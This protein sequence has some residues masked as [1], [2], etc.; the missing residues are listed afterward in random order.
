MNVTAKDKATSK[1]QKVTITA[2]TN[3]NESEIERMVRQARDHE[4]E[5]RQRKEL[6]DARNTADNMVYQT[7]KALRELGDKVPASERSD[8][9]SKVS[10]LKQ[11]MQGENLAEIKR[12][13]EELQNAFYA[14]SQQMYAQGQ[15][16]ATSQGFGGTPPQSNGHGPED[17]GEVVE[18]E[19]RE[20]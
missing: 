19:F 4:A 11:T 12:Q 14:L 3:L 6:I 13:T 20:A 16:G 9:E 7:E 8:I 18:G 15:P 5:D 17:E 10:A 1:E 2:S